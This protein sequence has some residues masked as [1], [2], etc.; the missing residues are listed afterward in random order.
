MYRLD[1]ALSMAILIGTER[2]DSGI[3]NTPLPWLIS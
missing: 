2:Y 3:R 1:T